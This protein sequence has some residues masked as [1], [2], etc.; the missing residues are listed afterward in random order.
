M[1]LLVNLQTA[2]GKS[3]TSEFLEA[4]TK[5]NQSKLNLLNYI[6]KESSKNSSK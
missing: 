4:F 5:L 3:N 2:G 1:E 6:R